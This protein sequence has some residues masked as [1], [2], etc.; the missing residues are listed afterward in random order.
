[1]KE[2]NFDSY[3]IKNLEKLFNASNEGL[4]TMLSDGTVTFFNK[5]FYKNF[6][7]NLENSTLEEWIELI[8]PEDRRTFSSNVDQQRDQ[9]IEKFISEYRVKHKKGYYIWIEAKGVATFDADNQFAYM[10]GSHSEITERKRTEAKI[11]KL[12]YHDRLTGLLNRSALLEVL[13]TEDDIQMLYFNLARFRLINDT[14]GYERANDVLKLFADT[15]SFTFYAIGTIYRVD[16]DEFAVILPRTFESAI[17][18]KQIQLLKR[19]FKEDLVKISG[20]LEITLNIGRALSGT[21]AGRPLIEQAKWAMLYG[22]KMGFDH[23][24]DFSTD[25][26]RHT[27][28]SYFMETS[29]TKGL[30]CE[31]FFMTFQPVMATHDKRIGFFE[32]LMRWQNQEYGFISPEEFIPVSERTRDIIALGKFAIERAFEMIVKIKEETG[33]FIPVAINIS[34]VQ[35]FEADF[36]HFVLERMAHYHLSGSHI[37]FEITET[38]ALE[39]TNKTLEVIKRFK[40]LGIM[41]ALDDFG[42]GFSSLNTLLTVPFDYIKIDKK[43]MREMVIDDEIKAFISALVYLCHAK[44]FRVVGEGVEDL[45]MLEAVHTIEM[46]YVQGY[47]YAKPFD[48]SHVVPY[49]KSISKTNINKID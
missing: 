17:L 7:L 8:H 49:I 15:L 42:S 38:V 22:K 24:I 16:A 35:L 31:E 39:V 48:A 45:E 19:Q 47:Y 40:S 27:Q 11:Y 33:D 1:M 2:N 6:E 25:I 41:F 4:W 28:R 12:A 23:C 32:C 10:V 13:E 30:V 29:M 5:N 3:D 20:G 9:H 44:G 18:K 26:Q 21:F 43:I 46:D 14:F 37:I 36:Y 34:A